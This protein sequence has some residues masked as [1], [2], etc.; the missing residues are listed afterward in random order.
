MEKIRIL[1][2]DDMP[3]IAEGIKKSLLK[4]DKV[5]VIGIANDGQEEYEMIG[6][7]QPDLV[8][9]D[10][11]MP[12]MNGIEVIEMIYDSKIPNKPK[13][14]LVTADRDMELY[15]RAYKN[16]TILVINKPIDE[17][18]IY[19]AIDEYIAVINDEMNEK[20]KEKI[21]KEIGES[22]RNI[23]KYFIDVIKKIFRN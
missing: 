12:K 11:Q 2:A 22:N 10:N 13:F 19:D 14:I 4:N 17:R 1:I 20:V 16:G 9:T 7:L 6:K 8:F 3:I 18:R 23:K 15:N 5:Q 21:S